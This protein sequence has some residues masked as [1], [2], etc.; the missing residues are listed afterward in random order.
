MRNNDMERDDAEKKNGPGKKDNG[1]KKDDTGKKCGVKKEAENRR[2]RTARWCTLAGNV[3][4]ILLILLCLPLVLP[5]AAGCQIY[6]VV[7]ASMEPAIPVGSLLY[8]REMEPETVKEGDIIAFFG[9]REQTGIITHRVVENRVVA[10][11][12]I[13]KG[14]ANEKNDVNAVP[15]ENLIGKE[16]LCIPVMGSVAEALTEGVGRYMAAAAVAAAALLHAMAV[17]SVRKQR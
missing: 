9:V 14:D 4:L 1:E 15:Y 2:N 10:G 8:I 17:F 13:T 3:L 7:S 12:F 11:E 6:T 5:R 16:L